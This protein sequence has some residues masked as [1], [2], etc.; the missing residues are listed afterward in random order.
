MI[1]TATQESSSI[2]EKASQDEEM[3]EGN[4]QVNRER[5]FADFLLNKDSVSFQVRMKFLL[6][7]MRISQVKVRLLST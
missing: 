3:G 6:S 2:A 7:N 4:M 5:R 1:F